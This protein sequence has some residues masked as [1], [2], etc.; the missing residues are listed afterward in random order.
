MD[1]FMSVIPCSTYRMKGKNVIYPWV[2][3]VLEYPLLPQRDFKIEVYL[4]VYLRMST[5]KI[6]IQTAHLQAL[7][8]SIKKFSSLLSDCLTYV[9]SVVVS[10]KK[11]KPVTW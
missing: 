6:C 2:L 10:P 5:F 3:L 8:V 11:Q 7:P 4:S 1:V 9:Y